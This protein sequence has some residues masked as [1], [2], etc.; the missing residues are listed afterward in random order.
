ME[1]HIQSIN[2]FKNTELHSKCV[3]LI[4]IIKNSQYTII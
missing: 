2:V 1:K 3:K 4:S